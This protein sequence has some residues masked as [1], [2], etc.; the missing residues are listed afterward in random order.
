[1]I[2][3]CKQPVLLL[4][5]LL[6]A[7]MTASAE[8]HCG[9]L[10]DTEEGPAM[11]AEAVCP[12]SAV[13]QG[14]ISNPSIQR[15][16]QA[17]WEAFAEVSSP[18]PSKR[19]KNYPFWRSWPEISEIFPAAPTPDRPPA[20]KTV[21]DIEHSF[22][23]RRSLL[24]TLRMEGS[25]TAP[26]TS[27]SIFASGASEVRMNQ[28][29]FKYIIDRQLWF[30]SGK[31]ASFE[32][33]LAANLP[34]DAVIVKANWIT[35]TQA[36]SAL[37]KTIDIENYYWQQDTRGNTWL[38]ISLQIMK[39]SLPQWFWSSFEHKDNPCFNRFLKT[40]DQFA[41]TDK[42]KM[43]GKLLQT[44]RKNRLNSKLWSH[45]ALNGTMTSFTTPQG[46][47]FILGNSV[48]EFGLQTTSSCPTCHARASTD[49]T[50]DATLMPLTAMG[51]SYYGTPDPGWFFSGFTPVVQPIFQPVDFLWSLALCPNAVGSKTQNCPL[52]AVTP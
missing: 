25:E 49:A 2:L 51:Q 45:Y 39:K 40:S 7:P 13:P 37:A 14:T 33:G 29:A 38:L 10:I 46:R 41:T 21:A 43:S 28:A 5:L 4:L 6:A 47:P 19:V 15:S 18:Q 27:C 44:F 12:G 52:D 36:E 30:T 8:E 22:N 24:Q 23:G 16:D 1:M 11:P 26:S 42:G 34:A 9:A 31:R 35:L 50:G 48:S 20:W 32:S 3:T 17:A